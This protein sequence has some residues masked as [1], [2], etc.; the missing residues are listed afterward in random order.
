MKVMGWK[1]EN[2]VSLCMDVVLMSGMMMGCGSSVFENFIG[3]Q[4]DSDAVSVR[5]R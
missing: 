5:H 2:V 1:M 3:E 4:R